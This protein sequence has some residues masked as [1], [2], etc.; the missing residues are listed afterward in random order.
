MMFYPNMILAIQRMF[1]YP[2]FIFCLRQIIF[3]CI[4]KLSVIRIQIEVNY[5]TH[6]A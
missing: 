3:L 1:F 4:A 2:M 5:G 6:A